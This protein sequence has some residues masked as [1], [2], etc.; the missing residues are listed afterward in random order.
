MSDITQPKRIVLAG[1]RGFMGRALTDALV[2]R[3]DD[4]VILTRSPSNQT[5]E[6]VREIA[7]DARSVGS[8]KNELDGAHA[9][10]NLVGRTVDC[11][12]TPA[13]R[14]V[15]LESR[16][17]SVNALGAAIGQVQNPPQIWV[18]TGTAHIFGDSETEIFTDGSPTGE[19][20][21]PDVGRAWEAAFDSVDFPNLRK[22]NLRI[23]FVLGRDGGALKTL[24]TL[25]RFGLGGTVGSG[26]QWM[27]W[28]H[29]ADM[30]QIFLRAIDD[31]TMNGTYVITS[32][33]PV[34]NKTFMRELRRAV[35]RP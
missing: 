4:V 15:I 34:D 6:R 24:A 30:V 33:N 28:I 27:S 29:M 1:G 11:R 26:R 17:N 20:F 23:S 9:I 8:W 7:W 2:A 31:S 12:K 25:A 3:G 16:V 19:G 22:V 10:V 18:Q 13:N 32:P 21:A 14:K 35:H 5:R